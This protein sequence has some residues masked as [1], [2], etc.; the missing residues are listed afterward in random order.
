[1]VNQMAN[2]SPLDVEY[3]DY[4]KEIIDVQVKVSEKNFKK[5]VEN[6]KF[7]Q[8]VQAGKCINGLCIKFVESSINKE[9]NAKKE[10][11]VD[12]QEV[13]FERSDGLEFE[14]E[15]LNAFIAGS[16]VF[17][18]PYPNDGTTVTDVFLRKSNE[19][20]ITATNEKQI[21]LEI[22]SSKAELNALRS[23]KNFALIVGHDNV[24][25]PRQEKLL[26]YFCSENFKGN[27]IIRDVIFNALPTR[28]EHLDLKKPHA[29]NIT[30]FFFNIDE[31]KQEAV[32]KFFGSEHFFLL[33]GPPGTGKSEACAEII[34]QTIYRNPQAK[35]LVA[36]DS[37]EAVDTLFKKIS[38]F[39]GNP[40]NNILLRFGHPSRAHG[41]SVNFTF[42]EK[43]KSSPMIKYLIEKMLWKEQQHLDAEV[44]RAEHEY[45]RS[46]RISKSKAEQKEKYDEFQDKKILA[47]KK[48]PWIVD[49]IKRVEEIV[50]RKILNDAR[51]YFC[52]N[53]CAAFEN[54]QNNY[55][56]LVV[57]D[58]ATQAT[59]PSIL[60]PICC[61]KKVLLAG[62]YQQLP[63]TILS[64]DE[65]DGDK[66]NKVKSLEITLFER[67][68][69]LYKKEFA[70]ELTMQYRMNDTLLDFPNRKFYGYLE[71]AS[72]NKNW[73][74]PLFFDKDIVFINSSSKEE[75][76]EEDERKEIFS[77]FNRGQISLVTQLIEAFKDITSD[78]EIKY[79]LLS[80]TDK[81]IMI[82]TPYKLQ[83]KLI[84]DKVKEYGFYAKTID[85]CQGQQSDLVILSLVRANSKN[86]IGFLGTE[87]RRFNVA[88]TRAKRQ[89]IVIGN[90]KTFE[91]DAFFK[92]WFDF[93][94]ENGLIIDEKELDIFLK[95]K[96]KEDLLKVLE[97]FNREEREEIQQESHL[98]RA[99][100][101][102]YLDWISS[103]DTTNILS[104]V[105]LLFDSGWN[106]AIKDEGER[107]DNIINKMEKNNAK[108]IL[109]AF[110][111]VRF[112][113][114]Y[115]SPTDL[116]LPYFI[117]IA[118]ND[119]QKIEE[120][121][122]KRG[123]ISESEVIDLKKKFTNAKNITSSEKMQ[124]LI[125]AANFEE[126]EHILSDIFE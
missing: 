100:K 55:F 111:W 99:F 61:A 47:F 125:N 38:K 113:Q 1:M 73:H 78:V 85:S 96:K 58:E 123:L 12:S 107:L 66:Y 69:N 79:R 74:L 11:L 23:E 122:L 5:S 52:T 115:L 84:T 32:R 14:K 121:M 106:V 29:V 126:T 51:I 36:C 63:P 40:L 15:A 53:T 27:K 94:K 35:V 2:E 43:Y 97:M 56:D 64:D 19:A 67:L 95:H 10:A 50:S 120:Q 81:N 28:N 116:G 24:T 90:I 89:L 108:E 48:K 76:L 80:L 39:F 34:C 119:A 91:N 31:S 37:N 33:E 62:D 7:F 57:I 83:K 87:K 118:E 17:F 110:Y 4:F 75:P 60:I 93:I 9:E 18:V 42:K 13:T 109:R 88:I 3:Y 124:K 102:K 26:K 44:K 21:I 70:A 41:E 82:I 59:E 104:S 71:S 117:K 46:K 6:K 92:E 105:K 30:D 68:Y 22:K 65:L 16:N 103:L 98:L 112:Q 86:K 25:Y 101:T 72:K 114:V 45:N 49:N 8:L 20:T 77:K 54:I